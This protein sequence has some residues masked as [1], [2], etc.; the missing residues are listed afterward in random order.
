[1][2]DR[3]IDTVPVKAK[4]ESIGPC[5]QSQR[6]SL[7][8]TCQRIVRR[9][10]GSVVRLAGHAASRKTAVRGGAKSQKYTKKG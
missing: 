5:G 9:V 4:L 7:V 3:Q 8:S 2:R 6:V 10:I 1:M